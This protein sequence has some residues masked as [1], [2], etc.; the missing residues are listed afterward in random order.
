MSR[1]ITRYLAL[2]PDAV[3][4]PYE[5]D[6]LLEAAGNIVDAL[7]ALG[8]CG[9]IVCNSAP[10]R[11]ARG[12]NG[13]AIV[14]GRVG[15]VTIISTV[16]PL[17]LLNRLVPNF[18]AQAVDVD[19][20]TRECMCN[21]RETF[22]FRGL[23]VIP[24]I[25][26]DLRND[27]QLPYVSTRQTTFPTVE[28]CVWLVDTIE[29]RP[30]NIKLSF[31]RDEAPWFKP[32]NRISIQFGDLPAR[33]LICYE[34]LTHIPDDEAGIYEGSSGLGTRRFLE[35]A[36]MGGSAAAAFSVFKSG[37]PVSISPLTP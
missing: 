20:Y 29:G 13:S 31:L 6:S 11:D 36:I 2:H 27:S 30:T 17:G 8:E 19:R 9:A 7:D 15:E 26:D 37:T 25:L 16:G 3:C 33:T 28:P 12:T 32:G 4:I 22:N 21:Q 35:V 24:W 14:F 5:S 23:E 34:R 18:T 1:M 10:R